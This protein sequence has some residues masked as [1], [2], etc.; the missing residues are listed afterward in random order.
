MSR[1]NTVLGAETLRAMRACSHPWGIYI[2]AD[3]VLHED[4]AAELAAAVRA[5][6]ADPEVEGLLVRY[7]H[8]YG[9][10]QTD[11]DPP[12]LVP[13]RGARGAAR[14]GARHPARTRA[15]R[16]SGSAPSTGGSG[17]G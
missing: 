5:H 4:G 3:E 16:A 15:R 12:P 10:F 14:P 6:D 7:L 1:R 2:Q 8:F 13:A 9:G 11:R 17:P